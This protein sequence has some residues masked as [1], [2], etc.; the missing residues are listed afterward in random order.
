MA[1]TK[2]KSETEIGSVSENDFEPK[3]I[4]MMEKKTHFVTEKKEFHS[5]EFGIAIS[6]MRL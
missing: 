3:T 1:E 6:I 5:I 4:L 2:K